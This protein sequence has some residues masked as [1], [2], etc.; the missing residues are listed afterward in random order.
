MQGYERACWLSQKIFSEK[1]LQGRFTCDSE[2]EGAPGDLQEQ[3]L[4]AFSE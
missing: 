2:S 3:L 4:L 1:I